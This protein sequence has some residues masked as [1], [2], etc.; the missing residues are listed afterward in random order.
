MTTGNKNLKK[1]VKEAF[2]GKERIKKR[3]VRGD[4][5]DYLSDDSRKHGI[6]GVYKRRDV[7]YSY[8][9]IT[10]LLRQLGWK[11]DGDYWIRRDDK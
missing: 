3:D 5:A 8:N 4:I 1:Y 2:K 9:R 10:N 11:S 6:N 7:Y